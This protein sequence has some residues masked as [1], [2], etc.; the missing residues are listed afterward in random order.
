M[1]PPSFPLLKPDL[2]PLFF[3][4][5][6]SFIRT[7]CNFHFQ[8]TAEYYLKRLTQLPFIWSSVCCILISLAAW[9]SSTGSLLD[10]LSPSFFLK[11]CVFYSNHIP[12]FSFWTINFFLPTIW[13]DASHQRISVY[14]SK[15]KTKCSLLERNY[16]T[17]TWL[18]FVCTLT[19]KQRFNVK[20]TQHGDLLRYCSEKSIHMAPG[21]LHHLWNTCLKSRLI[22]GL[23]TLLWI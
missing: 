20:T 9:Y 5:L 4:S 1:P 8:M 12:H 13:F 19:M 2:L 7:V 10:L 22:K 16:W 6:M 11:V 21:I 18:H 23:A 17:T 14:V 3:P 15:S